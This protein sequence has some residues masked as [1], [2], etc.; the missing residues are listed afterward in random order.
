MANPPNG[1]GNEF[2]TACL[3][4]FLCSL[5]KAEV[6]FVDKVVQGQSL[7][8]ILLCHTYDEAQ[9]GAGELVESLAVAVMNALCEFYFLVCRNEFFASYLYQIFVESGARTVRNAFVDF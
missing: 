9:I 1:I 8:L 5:Y 7:I 4:E 2:E 3:V 6:A